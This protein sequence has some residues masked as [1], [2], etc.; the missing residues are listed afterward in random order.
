V[1]SYLFHAEI[2]RE[3]DGR[4]SAGVPSLPGCATWGHSREEALRNLQDAV[5]AYNRAVER[6]GGTL[7]KEATRQ[8]TEEPVIAVTV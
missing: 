2:V 1:T 4:W 5:E 6:V 3:D 8:V 7:P